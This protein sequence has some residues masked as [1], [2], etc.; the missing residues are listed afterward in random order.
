MHF[1]DVAH[2][3]IRDKD[4]DSQLNSGSHEKRRNRSKSP[5]WRVKD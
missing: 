3:G 1:A 4:R 2:G 5:G